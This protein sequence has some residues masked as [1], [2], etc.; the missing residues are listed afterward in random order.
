[1]VLQTM[2]H[3]MAVIKSKRS[4]GYKPET[5]QAVA[6]VTYNLAMERCLQELLSVFGL[7]IGPHK[8]VIV[9]ASNH[10]AVR[11]GETGETSA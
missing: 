8:S 1:M 10:V 4:R 3:N 9:V 2:Y 5:K 7:L 6:L 11:Y